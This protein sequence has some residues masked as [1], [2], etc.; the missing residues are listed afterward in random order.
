MKKIK[1]F[2]VSILVVLCLSLTACDPASF[3]FDYDELKEKV[4]TV[5][6]ISYNNINLKMVK[7]ESKVLPFDFDKMEI[8]ETLEAEQIDAF[9]QD[10]SKTHFLMH[11][12]YSETAV[13]ISVR[14]VYKNGDFV[15]LSCNL[16]DKTAYRFVV[17]FDVNGKV[18]EV[19]G[20]FA[21]RYD[22]VDLVNKFFDTQIT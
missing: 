13:G 17:F 16:I 8:V 1:I 15:V 20:G 11:S 14:I 4:T 2:M 3:Y 18:K 9:L 6:L 19:I 10:L 5:E 7:D 22:Y 12:N 21:S